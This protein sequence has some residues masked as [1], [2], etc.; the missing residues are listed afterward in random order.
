MSTN[1]LN[2]DNIFRKVYDPATESLRSTAVA[3][4]VAGTVDVHID[5]TTDSIKIGDGVNI[6]Q[7]NPDGSINTNITGS[8]AIDIDAATGDNILVVGT[9][10]GN[11]GG[12]QHSFKIGSDRNLRVKDEDATN[13]LNS[14]LT[15]LQQKTEPSDVQNIRTINSGTDSILVPGVAS[16][17]T[18]SSIDSKLVS[19]V[20]GL[21]VNV[22]LDAFNVTP[23]NVQ[24]VGSIDGTKT[25]TKYGFVNN[26]R[27]QILASQNREQAITYADFGTKDQRVTR[28]EY[29]STTF[30][31]FI[32]RKDLIYSLIGTKYRRDDINWSVI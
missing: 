28:I 20:D 31:G 12:I 24:L 25:S 11:I 16:E 14:L 7:V 21:K 32:L 19:T 6:L 22:E 13:I 17:T 18:L 30:P 29:S 5:Q 8:F 10:D 26:I 2:T 15:E 3:S 23:D 1:Y 27:Q 4:F 9:E